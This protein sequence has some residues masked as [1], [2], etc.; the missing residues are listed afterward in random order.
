MMVRGFW[1]ISHVKTVFIFKK[2][3]IFVAHNFVMR[4]IIILFLL[5]SFQWI[6]AQTSLDSLPKNKVVVFKDPRLSVLES[7]QYEINTAILKSHARTTPGYRLMVVNTS[8]KD[9]AFKIRADL[10]QRFP[11][12]KIYM[13]FANPYIRMKFGNFKTK[14]EAEYYRRQIINMLDGSNIYFLQ[15]MI[16]IPPG[17]DLE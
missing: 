8:D 1:P 9:K 15:E 5:I 10:L 3:G 17:E 14:D 7:K 2:V 12:Q 13:W 16:E 11:E 6:H 4:L